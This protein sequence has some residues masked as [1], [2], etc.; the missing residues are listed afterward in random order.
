MRAN[1]Q[2]SIGDLVGD[3]VRLLAR[4]GQEELALARSEMSERLPVLTRSAALMVAGGLVVHAGFLALVAAAI[5]ALHLALPWWLS[6]LIV[7][8]VLG[9]GGY[10]LLQSGLDRLKRADLTPRRTIATMQGNRT[11]TREAIS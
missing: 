6:A 11:I 10:L 9:L 5:I 1:G 8:I 2:R 4:L 3:A 7:G